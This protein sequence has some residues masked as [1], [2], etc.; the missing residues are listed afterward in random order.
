MTAPPG[1]PYPPPQPQPERS[2]GSVTLTAI[3]LLA[4][5]A[6]AVFW[7][8]L[9]LG[10]AGVGRDSEEQA[11]IESFTEAYRHIA[12]D[13][14]GSP[15][16]EQVLGGALDGMVDALGDPY[17]E[18]MSDSEFEAALDDAYG[19]FDGIGIEVDAT[20]ANGAPC[21]E[22]VD[23]CVL[24][25]VRVL[26]GTPAEAAGLLAGDLITAVDGEG[27]GAAVEVDGSN[28]AEQESL[29]S[30]IRG[31]RGT[32][33][34]LTV[35]RAGDELEV[36]VTRD[37][38]AFED[39]YAATL[40][41]G[42]I[43]YVAIDNFSANAADDFKDEL[44]AFLVAGIEKLVV[45]VRDDPGGFVDVTV[46]ISSQFIEDGTVFWDEYADGSQVPVEATGDGIATDPGL[47]VVLL[48]NGGSASASEILGGALQDSGRAELVGET[49]FGKGSVQAWNELPGGTGG[50]RLSVARWLTRDKHSIDGVGLTPD[51]AVQ[52][53]GPRYHP[54]DRDVDP[55]ADLQLQTAIALLLDEPLPT[56]LPGAAPSP[57]VSPQPSN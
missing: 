29:F 42:R 45:D 47:D 5:G 55:D 28:G 48:V 56:T 7:A 36:T 10:N 44:E 15:V 38:I 57:V 49:T 40:A 16:P 11:A 24:E 32:D 51:H 19:H 35:D 41:D 14:I 20:A 34:T 1:R 9:T 39:V 54:T 46:E 30:R 31:E 27:P 4:L 12:N 50:I 52:L 13:Y 25:I 17:S 22:D 43:G 26:P 2:G 21:D 37:T 53:D 3:V 8:G 33:V 18:Y 6:G 23:D